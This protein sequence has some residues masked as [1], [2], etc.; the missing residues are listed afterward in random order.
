MF[1]PY[2]RSAKIKFHSLSYNTEMANIADTGRTIRKT[3]EIWV[4]TVLDKM[5]VEEGYK[6]YSRIVHRY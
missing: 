3:I 1:C 4:A 2:N 6:S 5:S